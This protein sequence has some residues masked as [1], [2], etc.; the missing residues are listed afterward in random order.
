MGLAGAGVEDQGFKDNQV[1]SILISLAPPPPPTLPPSS[2]AT[3][4][5]RSSTTA[6]RTTIA[7]SPAATAGAPTLGGSALPATASA[8]PAIDQVTGPLCA[9]AL[10]LSSDE[11]L[12]EGPGSSSLGLG[13]NRPY[14]TLKTVGVNACGD[15]SDSLMPP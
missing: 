8:A 6:D 5:G 15:V 13:M 11:A 9:G 12:T 1:G 4:P 3:D 14:Q 2:K 7:R 10:P